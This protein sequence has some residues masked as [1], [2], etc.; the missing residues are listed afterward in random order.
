MSPG[1]Q[2]KIRPF[3]HTYREPRGKRIA[4]QVGHALQR[5]LDPVAESV[6]NRLTAGG[7]WIRTSRTGLLGPRPL[8]CYTERIPRGA[9][10]GLFPRA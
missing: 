3:I 4:T 5:P 8:R 6:R 9:Q 10:Q 7:R 2:G 1:A